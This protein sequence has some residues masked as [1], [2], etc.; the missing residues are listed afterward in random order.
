MPSPLST[1]Q[2]FGFFSVASCGCHSHILSDEAAGPCATAGGANACWI[3]AGAAIA[4]AVLCAIGASM[5]RMPTGTSIVGATQLR[6][7]WI[8]VPFSAVG[9][10]VK[11]LSQRIT[12]RRPAS[13]AFAVALAD[14]DAFAEALARTWFDGVE[15]GPMTNGMLVSG[16]VATPVAV[17]NFTVS[18]GLPTAG[19]LA[20]TAAVG[21][22]AL[23]PLE[24][25]ADA[26]AAAV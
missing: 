17:P 24:A 11:E 19:V 15:A 13:L 25:A 6:A 12:T 1:M 9:V 10:T 16:M 5:M 2:A 21:E 8:T 3:A 20:V 18:A 14:A 7:S 22:L 26:A 23:A 4:T